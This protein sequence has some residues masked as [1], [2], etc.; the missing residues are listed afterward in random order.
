M[1]KKGTYLYQQVQDYVLDQIR[2]GM[3]CAGDRIPSEQDLSEQMKVSRLTVR[4]AY[5]AMIDAGILS[6]VQGK[7]TVVS[8]V[9]DHFY[10]DQSIC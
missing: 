5:A 6:A 7:G 9:K 4:K 8:E 1:K 10:L 2:E 3:L